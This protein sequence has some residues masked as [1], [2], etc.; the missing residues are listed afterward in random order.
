MK[1]KD[2]LKFEVRAHKKKLPRDIRQLIFIEDKDLE[3]HLVHYIR[4]NKK[5]KKKLNEATALRL[6]VSYVSKV[7]SKVI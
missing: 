6:C 4:T 3:K 5:L 7:V 2:L 1:V